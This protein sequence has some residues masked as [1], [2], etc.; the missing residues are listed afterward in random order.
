MLSVFHNHPHMPCTTPQKNTGE[1]LQ[2]WKGASLAQPIVSRPIP[3][4]IE[5]TD[6]SAYSD[7]SSGTGIAIWINSRWRAW[8]LL[9]GWKNEDRDIGWAE[10]IN[11]D[12]LAITLFGQ[13]PEGS[14]IKVFGENQGVVEGWWKGRSRN[15]A[16][17]TIFKRIHELAAASKC[18][19]L[20]C[21][22][23][24]AHNP[25]DDPSRGIYPPSN[26]LLPPIHIPQPLQAFITNF[27]D[28]RVLAEACKHR[29]NVKAD[30]LVSNHR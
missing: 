16:T 23:P 19:L 3:G 30:P 1:D 10:A 11:M 25:A 12:F 6:P 14:C 9:P 27:N 15:K 21:Y 17:N 24:S 4:P 28:P 2:W 29:E 7:A 26:L 18:A 8:H 13:C 5:V 20:T 22:V